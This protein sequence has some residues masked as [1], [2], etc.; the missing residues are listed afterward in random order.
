[1]VKEVAMPQGRKL[2]LLEVTD[3]EREVLQGWARRRKT[4]QGLAS[5]ARI[6]LLAA[7]GW[8]NSAVAVNAGG[9]VDRPAKTKSAS[10]LAT[11]ASPSAWM[12]CAR[13]R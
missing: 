9:K 3:E 2:K 4:A 7:E 6:V 8:S 1:M 11:H 10:N 12:T 5:R 13:A